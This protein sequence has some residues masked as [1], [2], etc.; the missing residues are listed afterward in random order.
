[1]I[2]IT[3]YTG[4]CIM[5]TLLKV[6]C[7]LLNSRL[8]LYCSKYNLINY[9]Q[10]GFQKGNRTSD[11]ILTLKAIVNKCASDQKGEKTIHMF[12]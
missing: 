5:N 7:S 11:H 8:T 9:E 1:M 10:I 6:L 2:L 3:N 12:C 4:I